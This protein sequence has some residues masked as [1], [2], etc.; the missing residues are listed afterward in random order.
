MQQKQMK[1]FMGVSLFSLSLGTSLQS[2]EAEGE[3]SHNQHESYSMNDA[4]FNDL[5]TTSYNPAL[6][7]G[8]VEKS[9]VEALRKRSEGCNT[10]AQSHRLL[11]RDFTIALALL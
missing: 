1:E 4:T 6:L 2:A 5:R 10:P 11:R 8:R 7:E 9:I 3:R